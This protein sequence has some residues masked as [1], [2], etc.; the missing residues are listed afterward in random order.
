MPNTI[1]LKLLE[2]KTVIAEINGKN[3]AYE[4]GYRLVA[5]ET[6][7]TQFEIVSIPQQYKDFT[8]TVEMQNAQG[9]SID[10]VGVTNNRVFSL[11]PEMA[12]AGYGSM[13][14]KAEQ[15]GTTVVWIPL[16]LKIWDDT[17][18]PNVLAP[19]LIT[20]GST[21]TLPPGSNATVKNSGTNKYVVLDFEIPKGESGITAP[22]AG[23]FLIGMDSD[24]GVIYCDYTN[25]GESPQFEYNTT[26]GEIFYIIGE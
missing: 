17:W 3:Y 5:G 15:D 6:N 25:Q 7:A 19:A 14:I 22:S 16:K 1:Q 8:I 12:V 2:N 4:G 23:M 26:T 11:P 13:T 21:E 24:T 9:V 18:K 20:V 10:S